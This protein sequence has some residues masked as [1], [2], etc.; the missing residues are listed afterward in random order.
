MYINM[1]TFVKSQCFILKMT[2]FFIYLFIFDRFFSFKL[3]QVSSKIV[4][5]PEWSLVTTPAVVGGRGFAPDLDDMIGARI[6][7]GRKQSPLHGASQHFW[8]KPTLMFITQC[9]F[10]NSTI[11]MKF[12]KSQL[13]STSLIPFHSSYSLS[14]AANPMSSCCCRWRLFSL[15]TEPF[16]PHV[17][18]AVSARQGSQSR[19]KPSSIAQCEKKKNFY[20][21]NRRST[22]Q[23]SKPWAPRSRCSRWR[24]GQSAS[25][26]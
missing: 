23:G 19:G 13:A 3:T 18:R 10:K 9:D 24:G 7:T 15:G 14:C 22:H 11:L 12:T 20:R 17:T 16:L 21:P 26:V 1:L 8:C 6:G 2:F 4:Q 5:M 25:E